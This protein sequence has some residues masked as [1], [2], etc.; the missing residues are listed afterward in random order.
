MFTHFQKPI[1]EFL[2]KIF[3]V[4]FAASLVHHLPKVTIVLYSHLNSISNIEK[5][6]HTGLALVDMPNHLWN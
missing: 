1:V 4:L 6:L 3:H 2:P 5:A